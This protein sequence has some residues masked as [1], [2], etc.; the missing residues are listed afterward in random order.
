MKEFHVDKT[1]NNNSIYYASLDTIYS[2]GWDLKT[3]TQK[4][5]NIDVENIE[6]LKPEHEGDLQNWLL[7]DMTFYEC[8][9]ALFNQDN[10]LVGYW[11]FIPMLNG[12]Y[13]QVKNGYVN[14][15]DITINHL[16]ILSPGQYNMYMVS[17]CVIKE[18]QNSYIFK[19]VID[20]FLDAL[21]LLSEK[22]IYF[23]EICTQAYTKY[24][25]R[26]CKKI[27]FEFYCDHKEEGKM[28]FCDIFKL[29]KKDICKKY[30]NYDKL[31]TNY[32]DYLE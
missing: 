13:E 5:M 14:D 19:T 9:R 22:Q 15:G 21:F 6:N 25:V 3:L 11:Q 1:N 26:L 16:P 20:S 12:Y 2:M 31:I 10:N 7:I 4:T 8:W 32:K 24:G 18:Y 29:L 17:L 27:G 28:F 23:K 30:V